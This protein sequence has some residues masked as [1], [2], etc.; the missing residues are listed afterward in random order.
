MRWIWI[1]IF[2]LLVPVPVSAE[3]VCKNSHNLV[4]ACFTIHGRAEYGNGTPALRIWRVG[5]RHKYGVF[6]DDPTAVPRPLLD[7]LD[8]FHH[9]VYADFDVCPFTNE[10]PGSMTMVCI[11]SVHHLVV[12]EYGSAILTNP[13]KRDE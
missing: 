9:S 6:P 3:Y 2:S 4:G 10:I 13:K 12:T 1:S 5:T 11:Q 8:T 7:G